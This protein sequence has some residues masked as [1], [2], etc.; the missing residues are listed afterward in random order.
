MQFNKQL[1]KNAIYTKFFTSYICNY[2]A[3]INIKKLLEISLFAR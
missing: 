3:N 1:L 2:V